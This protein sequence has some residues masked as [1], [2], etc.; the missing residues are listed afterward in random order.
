MTLLP[1]VGLIS[2]CFLT[3][4]SLARGDRIKLLR[5]GQFYHFSFPLFFHCSYLKAMLLFYVHE[6]CV[7][8]VKIVP[9]MNF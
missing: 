3:L 1:I 6:N 9:V 2:A 4:K 7:L 5:R 8:Y